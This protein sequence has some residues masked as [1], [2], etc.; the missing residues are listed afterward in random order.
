MMPQTTDPLARLRDIHLPQPV[1]PWPPAPGWWILAALLTAVVLYGLW[2]GWRH[3]RAN[4]YRRLALAQLAGIDP[5]LQDETRYLQAINQLLKQTALAAPKPPPVAA[6]S[7]ESWLRFLDASGDTSAFS[8]GPGQ[9][10][11]TGPYAAAPPASAQPRQ[12]QQL[13]DLV[14][15]WI[16]KHQLGRVGEPC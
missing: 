6:L 5:Q 13:H 9:W 4:R 11:L 2:R 16:K 3:R 15:R 10:L 7:G 12:L 14:E 1:S 8:D